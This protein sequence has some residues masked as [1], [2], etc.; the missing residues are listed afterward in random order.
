[1]TFK[2]AGGQKADTSD[3]G[4]TLLEPALKPQPKSFI[5]YKQMSIWTVSHSINEQKAKYQQQELR[6][7]LFSQCGT[8]HILYLFA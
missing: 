4:C 6:I 5:V 1:M 2:A 7:C 3:F 8:S